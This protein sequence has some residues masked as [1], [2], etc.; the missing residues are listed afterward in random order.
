VLKNQTKTASICQRNHSEN[1]IKVI[2]NLFFLETLAQ[3]A[4]IHCTQ[5]YKLMVLAMAF[6]TVETEKQSALSRSNRV[7]F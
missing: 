2:K 1:K 3:P 7:V 5:T 6:F 4:L